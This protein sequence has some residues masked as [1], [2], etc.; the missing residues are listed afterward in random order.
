MTSS[1]CAPLPEDASI[2]L[3]ALDHCAWTALKDRLSA[4]CAAHGD[5][6]RSAPL[7]RLIHDL[8]DAAL[9]QLHLAVFRDVLVSEM[10]LPLDG[11]DA[12][13]D[14][15]YR[16]EL[17]QHGLANIVAAC[18]ARSLHASTDFPAGGPVWVALSLPC[19]L[20]R[21]PP[22]YDDH[23]LAALGC[24]L[25]IQTA[26]DR[27]RVLICTSRKASAQLATPL[28]QLATEEIQSSTAAIASALGY[29]RADFSAAGELLAYSRNLFTRLSLPDAAAFAAALPAAF[30]EDT[31]WNPA[32]ASEGRF[33]NYRLRLAD[34]DSIC[35]FLYNVSGY[36]DSGGV[37]RTLWQVVSQT[38]GGAPLA[39]GAI[40]VEARISN[41]TRHYVPQLV[42]HKA[43][44]AVALGKNVL[45]DEER[46]WCTIINR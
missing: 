22:P 21:L 3:H 12:A 34:A 6:V 18:Q 8:L 28:R 29:G 15:L 41:I 5:A 9:N 46:R 27:T 11:D 38:D 25:S 44:E 42:E 20:L 2:T 19:R 32:F 35:S 10:G 14:S 4:T 17:A 40:L 33:E 31:I 13:I 26:G 39:Q 24:T 45:D 30:F 7:Q 43:R 23:A 37:I 16:A 1:S 36:R